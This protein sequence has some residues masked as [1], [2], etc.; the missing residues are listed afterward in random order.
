MLSFF[1]QPSGC[2][3]ALALL[4]ALS[5]C[6]TTTG[7]EPP[8]PPVATVS[9]SADIQPLFASRCAPCHAGNRET[10]GVNLASHANTLASIGTQYGEATVRPGDADGSSLID[11]IEA[12]PQFGSRMPQGQAPLSDAEIAQVRAWI[13]AGAPD[14]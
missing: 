8:P 4:V 3:V 10:S 2:A 5:G 1:R 7:P 9:F 13:D 14:N 12:D 6:D 11:K